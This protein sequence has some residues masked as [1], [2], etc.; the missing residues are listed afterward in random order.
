MTSLDRHKRLSEQVNALLVFTR[1]RVT[2][3]AGKH[4][5]DPFCE[6]DYTCTCGLSSVVRELCTWRQGSDD[7]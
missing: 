5:E 3:R 4:C 1:H 7:E 2:C 6:Y